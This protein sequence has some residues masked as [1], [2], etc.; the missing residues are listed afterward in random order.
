M[1]KLRIFSLFTLCFLV[2]GS[3]NAQRLHIEYDFLNDDFNY[4][5]VNKAGERKIM[6]RPVVTRNH[7][8]K[9][10]VK[11]YN[12]F[13]YTA[14]ANYESKEI[15]DAPNINFLKLISPLD[16]PTGSTSFL[17]SIIG[18]DGQDTRGKSNKDLWANADANKALEKVQVTYMTLYKA[19]QITNNIDFVMQKVHKLK[20]N[21]YLP[22]DSIKSFTQNLVVNLFGEN[23]VESQ[24][25]LTFA[26]K[27]NQ[28]VNNDVAMLQTHANSFA[29]A[30][31]RYTTT[32]PKG[33]KG[34]FE[35]EGYDKVVQAWATQA[36]QFADNFDSDLLLNKLDYL[37]TEYQAI[38]NTPFHFNTSD[39]AKGDEITVTIKFYK[40]PESTD[41]EI[42]SGDISNVENLTQI[43]SQE[44]DIT[45]KGDLK[46][47]SSVG[48]SFPYYKNNSEFINKDS[49]IT[50]IEGNN[51]TPNIS[52]FLN[53]YPYNGKNAAIGGT[54]G[55]G[56]PISS[57]GKNFNFLMGGSTIFGSDNRLII[58][59]GA[60]LGQVNKLD[61]GYEVGDMLGDALDLV[62]TR[63][64]YQW[65][66]FIGISFALANV[67]K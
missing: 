56:V 17:N 20:Y 39:I 27:I 49:V 58:N 38:M 45:V 30:Y 7:N 62:P 29:N 26:N 40:N 18:A 8:V 64:A 61:Q 52:A 60:T 24:D 32:S 42:T 21:P 22:T 63:K 36:I 33:K 19:E 3:A 59:F 57:D 11:N 12:P 9:I 5:S 43:K 44:V 25:F 2:L 31:N 23:H 50:S 65:G 4:Y 35:G 46:I 37:E 14:V 16:L 41:G 48:V 6:S 47:N 28:T 66:G 34:G 53:F 51:F 1:K 10:E 55:V 67:K 13:V 54:F 15:A